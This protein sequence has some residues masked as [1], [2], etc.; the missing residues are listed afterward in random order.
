[1]SE[2]IILKCDNCQKIYKS[3]T[4]LNAHKIKCLLKSEKKSNLPAKPISKRRQLYNEYKEHCKSKGIKQEFKWNQS[5]QIKAFMH[6]NEI[7][8]E[9]EIIKEEK[10]EEKPKEVEIIKEEP[11][12][13]KQEEKQ[14]EILPKLEEIKSPKKLKR[15]K[16]KTKHKIKS[17]KKAIKRLA[18]KVKR[19]ARKKVFKEKPKKVRR[20]S[21][22]FKRNL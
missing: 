1:M 13:E 16:C 11:K 3:S 21:I 6:I 9:V 15:R 8:K 19:A 18:I 4:W 5:K 17:N 14:E 2:I 10:Q 22:K 7:S 12:E 20:N